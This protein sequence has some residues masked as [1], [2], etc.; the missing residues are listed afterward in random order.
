MTKWQAVQCARVG[1]D[2]LFDGIFFKNEAAMASYKQTMRL[3]AM[4]AVG[5]AGVAEPADRWLAGIAH[6]EAAGSPD[7]SDPKVV[8]RCLHKRLT[9]TPTNFDEGLIT[10]LACSLE[11]HQATV[12]EI[13]GAVTA[14]TVAQLRSFNSLESS[15]STSSGQLVTALRV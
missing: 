15:D 13:G 5:I 14:A 7:F 2:V 9:G 12:M 11:E 4:G 1:K 6:L 10:R 3:A 8:A